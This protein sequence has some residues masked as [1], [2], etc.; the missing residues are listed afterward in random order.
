M[1]K[2]LDD[3]DRLRVYHGPN[4]DPAGDTIEKHAEEGRVNVAVGDVFPLLADALD[5]GRTWLLDF[6]D[7][8]ITISAD[9]YDVLMAYM[10]FHRSA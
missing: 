4:G 1:Q 6:E 7:E 5:S 8:E 3:T 2:K 10:H 9:L